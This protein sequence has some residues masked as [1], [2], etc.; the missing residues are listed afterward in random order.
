MTRRFLLI[1]ILSALALSQ[2]VPDNIKW[3]KAVVYGQGRQMMDIARPIG[4]GP[5]PAVVAI[6]RRRLHRGRPLELLRDDRP[7]GRTRLCG[8]HRGLPALSGHS[9]SS[10]RAGRQDG[11]EIS[12]RQRT[13][14]RHRP[15]AHRR[16][17]R[18]RWRY[19]S[20]VGGPYN[21]RARVRG[22]R[23]EPRPV[24]QGF[25]RGELQ[26]PDGPDAPSARAAKPRRWCSSWAAT[27]RMRAPFT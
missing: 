11:C 25:L 5:Y 7:V 26:R 1:P 9:I 21:R 20:A 14:I 22:R 16:D 15:R 19:F 12:A 6:H 27:W 3:E 18:Y 8:R 23:T 2:T 24:I 4:D 17:R 13:E 10:G